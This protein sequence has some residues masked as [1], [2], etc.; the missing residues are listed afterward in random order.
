[1]ITRVG[2]HVITNLVLWDLCVCVCVCVLGVVGNL[3]VEVEDVGGLL[4]TT[5][6]VFQVRKYS[7][8]WYFS[9]LHWY[10][11]CLQPVQICL[12]LYGFYRYMGTMPHY[13]EEWAR[14]QLAVRMPHMKVELQPLACTVSNSN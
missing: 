8:Q 5:Q 9:P 6:S 2:T 1:M 4:C 12:Y 14:S 3:W 11:Q 13:T 10:R 7:F